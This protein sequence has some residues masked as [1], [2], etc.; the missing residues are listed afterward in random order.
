M[1]EEQWQV[2]TNPWRMLDFLSGKASDRKLRLFE[3]ACCRRIWHLL[4]DDNARRGVE[5]AEYYAD[6]LAVDDKDA[7]FCPVFGPGDDPDPDGSFAALEAVSYA[8]VGGPPIKAAREV[9]YYA[10]SA[11]AYAAHDKTVNGLERAAQCRLLRDLIGNPFS[12]VRVDLVWLGWSQ[13]TVH[14]LAQAIYDE[15]RFEDMPILADALEDAGCSD[16]QILA[17]CRQADEHYRGC[18]VVDLLL[19]KT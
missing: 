19:K 11:A 3:C 1:T 14:K 17:H 15:R 5:I 2:C 6:G 18:W 12:S 7:L 13:G 8:V 9:S 16:E 10:A 4:T